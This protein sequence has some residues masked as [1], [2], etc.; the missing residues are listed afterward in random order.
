MYNN[1]A[2]V[3]LSEEIL[4]VDVRLH[5]IHVLRTLLEIFNETRSVINI[6]V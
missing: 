6:P 5:R 3:L 4:A 1:I 2:R